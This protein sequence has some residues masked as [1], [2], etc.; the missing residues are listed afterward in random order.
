[1]QHNKGERMRVY[2]LQAHV[3]FLHGETACENC[4]VRRML[5]DK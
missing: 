2:A 3:Q 4:T 5:Q 1:M